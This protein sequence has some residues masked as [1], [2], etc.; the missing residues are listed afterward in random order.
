MRLPLVGKLRDQG[1]ARD[2]RR[3]HSRLCVEALENRTTPDATAAFSA[4]V[5]TVAGDTVATNDDLSIELVAGKV[6]VFKD[7]SSAAKS[8]L[9]T[10]GASVSGLKLKDLTQIIV[11]AG[12]G[13]NRVAVD[14]KITTP[15]ELHGG[16][17]DD[18]LIAGGGPTLLDGGDGDD[19]LVGG[20]GNDTFDG[21]AGNDTLTGGK[22]DDI[23]DGGPGVNLLSG[24]S[25]KNVWV[26]H[27]TNSNDAISVDG[28]AG[29]AAVVAGGATVRQDTFTDPNSRLDRVIVD[30]GAGND[31]IAVTGKIA[32]TLLGDD[33]NDTL[34]GGAGN[35]YLN[36]GAGDDSLAG[37]DGKDVLF[38]D[39]GDDTVSGG[40]GNDTIIGSGGTDTLTPGPGSNQLWL[41]GLSKSATNIRRP[42]VNS[43]T[44]V[45]F[46]ATVT[47]FGTI[48]GF[49][50]QATATV[51]VTGTLDDRG[52]L[53]GSFSG[54]GTGNGAGTVGGQDATTQFSFDANGPVSGPVTAVG[55]TAHYT[56]TGKV[57]VGGS[58][59]DGSLSG[60][61][62]G[63]VNLN[64]GKGKNSIVNDGGGAMSGP[65][66]VPQMI[67]VSN[68][69]N[70]IGTFVPPKGKLPASRAP[71]LLNL[72]QG[73]LTSS[74]YASQVARDVRVDLSGLTS[75][76]S[77]AA[78]VADA[79]LGIPIF[80]P[81]VP[82]SNIV[83][84]PETWQTVENL[85]DFFGANLDG[86]PIPNSV[87]ISD[88]AGGEHGGPN[89]RHYLGQAVDVAGMLG[90]EDLS[91]AQD[92]VDA[93]WAI[94][95]NDLIL[96]GGN[97]GI[98]NSS[99]VNTGTSNKP[100]WTFN[101]ATQNMLKAAGASRI[102]DSTF[103]LNGVIIFADNNSAHIHIGYSK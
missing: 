88:I 19:S 65:F 6:T 30:G 100:V 10:N 5:L 61:Y 25:G 49:H 34:L 56:G 8:A 74:V 55:F 29:T 60:T 22:K 2:W 102:N 84:K 79:S 77:V 20:K 36:G 90:D 83:I 69:V 97:I 53:I 99:N 27:G 96:S 91:D 46:T 32:A 44:Q 87:D 73:L 15:A 45:S 58:E 82:K 1:S 9:P 38:G 72:Y 33:G 57:F 35:D 50:G 24:G 52:W 70:G 92:S 31:S 11:N 17:N 101:S 13:D 64:T 95:K 89:S 93:A 47:V 76:P 16:S 62:S 26:I 85:A 4:G 71:S 94:I 75:G 12:D 80:N 21:G 18:V 48:Q 68:I 14:A 3:T 42:L 86:T 28:G 103:K 54:S 37:G 51:L 59:I 43:G 63:V 66:P 40:S 98:G 7:A 78:Q 81:H 41:N 23:L 39:S 67:V